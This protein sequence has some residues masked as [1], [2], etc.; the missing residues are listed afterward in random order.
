M[1]APGAPAEGAVHATQADRDVAEERTDWAVE[2]T[3]LS[4]RYGTLHAVDQLDLKIPTGS[5][6][7]LIGPNGAGKS[8]TFSMIATL[9]RPT[10]GSI[11][12]LGH[13]PV[14]ESRA[15][16]TTSRL[17]A[18]R[19][20]RVRQPARRRVPAVLRGELP[21][22]AASSGRISWAACSNSSTSTSRRTRHGQF[23]S[24]GMK[25][26]LSLARTLV[27][28]PDVLVLDEPASGL[29]PWCADRAPRDASVS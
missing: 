1:K 29:D 6:Y 11:S 14:G 23:P 18:R 2:T 13:D 12:V 7:G 27:H 15:G 21:G 5:I 3:A 26:R 20:R 8:T 25:Q 16:A 17:H 28:D 9:L 19:P 24:R 10:S 4:K 22:A